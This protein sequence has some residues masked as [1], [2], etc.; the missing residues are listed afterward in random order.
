[1][2]LEIYIV[3][4]FSTGGQGDRFMNVYCSTLSIM[5]QCTIMQPSI[6]RRMKN[7]YFFI[8]QKGVSAKINKP[9]PYTQ[10]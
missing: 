9:T 1:M 3:K 5:K 6:N 7:K 10:T 8:Q 4:I 2:L